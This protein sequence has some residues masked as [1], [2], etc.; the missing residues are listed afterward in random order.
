MLR[1][2]ASVIAQYP[3]YRN[4]PGYIDGMSVYDI[5]YNATSTGVFPVRN[6]Y[7]LP[8]SYNPWIDNSP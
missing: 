8:T 1:Y 2:M 5:W 4:H 7:G 6:D 3:D